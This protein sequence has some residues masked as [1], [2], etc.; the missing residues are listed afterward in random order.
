MSLTPP[1][2]P[3]SS[4]FAS[5]DA[6]VRAKTRRGIFRSCRGLSPPLPSPAY[7]SPALPRAARMR[8]TAILL[9]KARPHRY[10]SLNLS[11][12]MRVAYH[13]ASSAPVSGRREM[14]RGCNALGRIPTD[15]S[16]TK[17]GRAN[18]PCLSTRLYNPFYRSAV[19]S[20]L[21]RAK[22]TIVGDRCAVRAGA[23]GLA[24][25][26]V[27]LHASAISNPAPRLVHFR[28]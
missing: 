13:R 1:P 11:A 20:S 5:R 8:C 22:D 9:I 10:L 21:A 2:P 17:R 19:R 28:R 16:T 24:R 25:T 18:A 23:C 3:S 6:R 14:N 7:A 15:Q 27:S 26:H 12:W 4:L